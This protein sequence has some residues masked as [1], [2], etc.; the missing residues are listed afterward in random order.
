[1]ADEAAGVPAWRRGLLPW[2]SRFVDDAVFE[3]PCGAVVRVAQAPFAAKAGCDRDSANADPG[4]TGCTVWDGAFVLASH[5]SQPRVAAALVARL[6]STALSSS[7]PAPPPPLPLR[8]LEL[9]AGTGLAGLAA[10]Y[11]L[12]RGS[13][14][15]LSDLA[16]LAA[17][18][19]ASNA[20]RARAASPPPHCRVSAA[21]YRWGD[22]ASARALLLSAGGGAA[23]DLVIGA[24]LAYRMAN[25]EPLLA[26]LR[27][28]L[29]PGGAALFALDTSHCPGAVEALRRGAAAE[30]FSLLDVPAAERDPDYACDEVELV[31]LWRPA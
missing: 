22:A 4:L 25:V 24:D 12:P 17:G 15:T 18:L 7:D 20:A 31:E 5:L 2:K 1:M 8:L 30:G 9:G 3:A 26:A 6:R 19:L 28:T 14:V 11:A 29:R 27:Q 23:F 21:A 16:P 13:E 10:A